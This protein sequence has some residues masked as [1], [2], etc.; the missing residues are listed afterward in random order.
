MGLMQ[1]LERQELGRKPGVGHGSGVDSGVYRTVPD[2]RV[3]LGVEAD[4]HSAP[5]PGYSGTR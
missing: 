3:G 5:W 4:P 1:G 2:P